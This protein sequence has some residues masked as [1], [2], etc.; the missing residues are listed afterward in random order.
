MNYLFLSDFDTRENQYVYIWR[1]LFFFIR[2][3]PNKRT[4][5]FRGKKL[6]HIKHIYKLYIWY[7]FIQIWNT[8]QRSY[9]I[10]L[11]LG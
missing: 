11:W 8:I 6:S 2:F 7:I 5:F 4:S 3:V 1:V 9:A 10:I